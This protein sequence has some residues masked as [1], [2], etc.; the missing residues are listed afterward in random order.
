M[1]T[2]YLLMVLI[3]VLPLLLCSCQVPT[4]TMELSVPLTAPAPQDSQS[5]E[6]QTKPVNAL[7]VLVA[8][9]TVAADNG[10]K[11]YTEQTADDDI[12][13]LADIDDS[14]NSA[15]QSWRHPE[16]P[17]YLTATRHKTEILIL[18][19]SPADAPHNP[20]TQKLFST[21]KSQLTENLSPFLTPADH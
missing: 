7:D 17:V 4:R 18:L 16:L 2:Q 9:E 14:S 15:V 11:P 19:N 20:R 1:K 5:I 10:L 12:L 8:V 13:G 3:A 6:I 21:I